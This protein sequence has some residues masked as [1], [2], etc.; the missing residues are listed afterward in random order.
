MI[1]AANDFILALGSPFRG[2]FQTMEQAEAA[3]PRSRKFGYDNRQAAE[4]YQQCL[5]PRWGDYALIYW[6]SRLIQGGSE[7]LDIGG[8]IGVVFYAFEKYLC[9]PSDF[10]WVVYDLPAS[11]EAG[12]RFVKDHPREALVFTTRLGDCPNPAILLASGALQYIDRPLSDMLASFSSP[13]KHVLVNKLPVSDGPPFVTLQDIGPSVCPY[14]AFN[15]AEF[16]ASL[17]SSGYDLVDQ[18]N[19]G[20]LRCR[21]RLH[22]SRRASYVGMYFRL[23]Q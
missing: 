9:Y 16:T 7:L 3:A 6:L 19:I 8:N 1:R 11:V 10:K 14:R 15:R 18:W 2:L 22:P 13:P 23:S 12:K 17:T 4:L 5:A 21:V 20:D